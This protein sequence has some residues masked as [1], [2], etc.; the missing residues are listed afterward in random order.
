MLSPIGEQMEVNFRLEIVLAI[1]ASFSAQ[2]I[3]IQI[4]LYNL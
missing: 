4:H 2:F 1:L 3:L